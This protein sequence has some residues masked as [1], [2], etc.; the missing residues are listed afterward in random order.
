MEFVGGLGVTVCGLE[1]T[2]IE[3]DNG[4]PDL[5]R[6]KNVASAIRACVLGSTEHRGQRS[7]V[8]GGFLASIMYTAISV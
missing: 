3:S 7:F 2:Y 8:V 6:S 1:E 5:L 4:L